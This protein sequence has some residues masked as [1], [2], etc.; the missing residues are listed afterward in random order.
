ML[1]E[2]RA[3]QRRDMQTGGV[4]ISE[5]TDFAVTQ[6]AD[7]GAARI[8]ADCNGNVVDFLRTQ[9]LVGVDFPAVEDLAAQRH[10]RLV[11]AIARL[12]GAATGRI[13]FDEEQLSE[14]RIAG[15]AIGELRSEERRGG[16]E[17][18]STDRSGWR[19]DT[20]KK[21]RKRT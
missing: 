18:D 8:D 11:F 9:R 2:Q 3:Q 7:I 20:K 21:K 17:W 4:G 13:A 6:T 12:L 10:D 1:E 14:P 16:N 5:H 15:H 19:R